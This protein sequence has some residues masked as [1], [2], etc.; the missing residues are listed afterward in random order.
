[1]S[2]PM[3]D[4]FGHKPV[5]PMATRL[6]LPFAIALG[7]C[8][9]PLHGAVAGEWEDCGVQPTDK[10]EAACST[11]I[12]G[13]SRSEADRTRAYVNR[14]RAHWRDGKF[15]LLVADAEAALR[16]DAKSVPALLL[17]GSAWRRKNALE[18]ARADFDRAL[19]HDPNTI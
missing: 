3:N 15:D 7:L 18:A 12:D 13:P 14:A 8:G 11:I 1:M 6:L 17:R 9:T 16:L 19:E 10:T 5:A 2:E 4:H